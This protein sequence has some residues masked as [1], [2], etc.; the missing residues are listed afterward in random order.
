MATPGPGTIRA[1]VRLRML[2]EWQ[3]GYY[4]T[5]PPDRI[6]RQQRRALARRANRRPKGTKHA[7]A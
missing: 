4:L 3:R 7:H 5:C 2:Q 6:T 1:L